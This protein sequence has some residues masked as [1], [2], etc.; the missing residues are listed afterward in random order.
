MPHLASH[1]SSGFR[2][3]KGVHLAA[4]KFAYITARVHQMIMQQWAQ[5]HTHVSVPY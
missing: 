2:V 1:T 4:S 3:G 5:L